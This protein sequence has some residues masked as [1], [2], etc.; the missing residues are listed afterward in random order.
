[1]KIDFAFICDY[2]DARGKINAL[3]IGFDTIYAPRVPCK[4]PIF[5]F[6]LQLRA[7]VLETGTKKLEVHIMDEDG[8]DLIPAVSKIIQIRRPTTGTETIARVALQF[9]N[10]KFPK[11]GSYTIRAVLDDNEVACVPLNVSLP[12]KQLPGAQ[13]PSVN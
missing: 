10:V 9:G 2:A 12:P 1:M 11:H 8:K 5:S 6:V 7:N 3:G 4:H 13:S